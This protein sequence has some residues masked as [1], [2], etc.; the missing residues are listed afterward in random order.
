MLMTSSLLHDLQ[1]VYTLCY[2]SELPDNYY[3]HKGNAAIEDQINWLSPRSPNNII[4]SCA[5]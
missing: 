2:F 4:I 3:L 1:N 5:S